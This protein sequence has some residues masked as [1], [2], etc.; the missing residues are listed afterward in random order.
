MYMGCTWLGQG[1]LAASFAVYVH[2]RM[3]VSGYPGRARSLPIYSCRYMSHVSVRRQIHE[4]RNVL[5]LSYSVVLI[6]EVTDVLG[7]L[8]TLGHSGHSWELLGT[9]GHSGHS[10]A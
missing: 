6:S 10:W 4:I 8:G 9:R 7:T 2:T 3:H 1:E 5:I